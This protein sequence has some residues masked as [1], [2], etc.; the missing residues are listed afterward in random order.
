M[1]LFG[2]SDLHLSHRSNKPMDVFGPNWVGHTEKMARAWDALVRPDDV[3]LVP[4]DISWALKLE[5]ADLDLQWLGARPGTKILCRGNH[6]Y[7]WQAIGRVRAALP[8]SCKALQNDAVDLGAYVVCGTRL[9][10]APGQLDFTEDDRRIY[11]REIGRL[12][13]S[14]EAGKKLAAGRPLVVSVHYPPFAANGSHTDFSRL[15][16]ESGA[17][18]CVYGHLHGAR[19]HRSAVEGVREGVE[20][21]LIAC[22]K[23]DFVPKALWP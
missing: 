21:H 5:E 22:D 3:V 7:W 15:I 12:K 1:A 14:L 2:I 23:L 9:W 20:F 10:A 16:C 8:P 6:D 13:M 19:A 11:E 17:R 4:G 18:L